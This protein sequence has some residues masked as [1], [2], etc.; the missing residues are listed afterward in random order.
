LNLRYVYF[1]IDEPSRDRATIQLWDGDDLLGA[2][3][4]RK[5]SHLPDDPDPYTPC[6]QVAG[7]DVVERFRRKGFGTKLYEEAARQAVRQGMSLCSDTAGDIANEALAFWEKQVQKGRAYW[8]VPGPPEEEGSNYDYG[9]FVLRLP[10]SPSLSGPGTST[11]KF[12]EL[13]HDMQVLIDQITEDAGVE[14]VADDARIPV[15]MVPTAAFPARIQGHATGDDR[16]FEDYLE[17]P[18]EEYPPVL[19]A[20]GYW[21]DGR[22]RLW[23]ARTRDVEEIQTADISSLVPASYIKK[24]KFL[25]RMR[26]PIHL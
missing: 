9:R 18:T 3:F 1:D 13:P 4:L 25:G 20:H 26:R 21:V 6:W 14:Y 11:M 10:I 7:I 15:G 22:H 12:S 16:Q 23:A 5:K 24:A 2:I 19:I 17:T 8:E